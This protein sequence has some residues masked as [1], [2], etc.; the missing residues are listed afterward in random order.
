M[1]HRKDKAVAAGKIDLRAQIGKATVGGVEFALFRGLTYTLNEV[2]TR[3]TDELMRAFNNHTGE[4]R[5]FVD[6]RDLERVVGG[7][8]QLAWYE[9]SPDRDGASDRVKAQQVQAVLDALKK[10]P[11]EIVETGKRKAGETVAAV[12]REGLRR[13]MSTEEILAE[14]RARFPDSKAGT[15]DVAYYKYQLKKKAG[16]AA[17]GEKRIEYEKTRTKRGKKS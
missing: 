10:D 4:A 2:K 13:S 5:Q 11:N 9:V 3:L 6:R 16:S 17:R 15:R 8:L 1:Q 12:I 14:V 7:E